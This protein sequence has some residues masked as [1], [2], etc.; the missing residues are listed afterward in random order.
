MVMKRIP[1]D[2]GAKTLSYSETQ[3]LVKE[4]GFRLAAPARFLFYFPRSL[5]KLRPLESALR[6]VPLGAQFYI[7]GAKPEQAIKAG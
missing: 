4:G 1:F 5:A 3:T 6:R 2:R 7:L